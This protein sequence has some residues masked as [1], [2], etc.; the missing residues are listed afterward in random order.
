[1]IGS[2]L[3][4]LFFANSRLAADIASVIGQFS[5]QLIRTQRRLQ[6]RN[7]PDVAFALAIQS[8]GIINLELTI[9]SEDPV[10]KAF[11]EQ[12]LRKSYRKL[13]TGLCNAQPLGHQLCEIV[14]TTEPVSLQMTDELTGESKEQDL[15]VAWFPKDFKAIDPRS[16]NF[17]VDPAIDD[18]YGV[19][20][21]Y[22]GRT[23][24]DG[25]NI[26]PREK[27]VWW[28]FRKE[29]AFGHLGGLPL[30]DSMYEG[31]W[32]KSALRFIRNRYMQKTAHPPIKAKAGPKVTIDGKDQNGFSYMASQALALDGGGVVVFPSSVDKDG[33]PLFDMELLEDGQRGDMF[34][35]AI[36]SEKIE[37]LRG[38]LITDRAAT[39]GRGGSGGTRGGLAESRQHAEVMAE[40]QETFIDEL[41]DDVVQPQ[42]VD[43]IGILNFGEEQYRASKTRLVTSGIS[44]SLQQIYADLIAAVIDAEKAALNG[45]P[46]RL[47]ERIDAPNILRALQIPLRPAAEL[48]ELAKKREQEKEQMQAQL[49]GAG[50]AAP[51]MGGRSSLGDP[52]LEAAV[53]DRLVK[54]GVKPRNGQQAAGGSK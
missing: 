13:A 40:S 11:M 6:M 48:E 29:A 18:W 16:Y 27:L 17:M 8:A 30:C 49:A 33:N 1:M 21:I 47:Y 3:V 28:C 38:G 7:A 31:W 41:V 32:Y 15:P 54:G 25:E 34:Q 22:W 53:R 9:E 44:S 35:H 19:Q 23:P 5:P 26:V 12:V 51:A 52:E 10:I 20:Q 39:S 24:Q 50:G 46:I 45:E 4:Q 2:D 43:R 36:D 14:W 37:I 42:V